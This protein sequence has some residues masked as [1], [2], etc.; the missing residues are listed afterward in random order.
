MAR[1]YG[2]KEEIDT[3]SVKDFFDK[4]AEKDV[5]NLMTITS[6]H[7]KDNLEKRQKEEIEVISNKIDF[8]GKKLLEIGCGL[9]RWAEYFQDKCSEYAGID[10]SE[11]LIEIA[12]KNFNFPNCYFEKLSVTEID[13]DKLP[14]KGPFDIIFIT[15][16]LIYLNDEDIKIMVDKINDITHS[17]SII[18]IRETISVLDTR[19]TLKDFYSEELEVDYNAIYRTEDELLKF[20]K[21]IKNVNSIEKSTIYADLNDFDETSYMYFI[22]R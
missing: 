13:E 21:E 3:T 8:N 15:G 5:E 6:Y 16:V 1:L 7:D 20:F 14:V 10:Y 12:K 17:N 19:L 9:G 4:R 22:L 11:K 2:K 18:Y